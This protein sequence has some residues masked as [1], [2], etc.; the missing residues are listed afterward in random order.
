MFVA[1]NIVKNS[2]KGKWVYSS[3][4]ITFDGAG[5]GEHI[6]FVCLGHIS[7]KFDA[8]ESRE[9]FL[10]TNVSDFSFAYSVINKSNI[11]NIPVF[12]G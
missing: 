12:N 8:I 10:K 2:G 7:E 5:S 9:V 1:T 6:R 4:R 11:L 3:Y